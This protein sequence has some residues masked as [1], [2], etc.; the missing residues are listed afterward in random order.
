MVDPAEMRF[1]EV[2]FLSGSLVVACGSP[3]IYRPPQAVPL[4]SDERPSYRVTCTEEQECESEAA[5]VCGTGY[6]VVNT[7]KTATAGGFPAPMTDTPAPPPPERPQPPV[8]NP[9]PRIE[10]VVECHR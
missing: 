4:Q 1:L 6:H 9:V 3:D 7:S 10:L 2:S 5:R 8:R